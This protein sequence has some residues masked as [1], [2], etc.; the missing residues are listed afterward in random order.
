MT[1]KKGDTIKTALG[2]T[3]T[4]YDVDG[5]KIYYKRGD[6]VIDWIHSGNVTLIKHDEEG[7]YKYIVISKSDG[8]EYKF[9]TLDELKKW[10]YTTTYIVSTT[11][12]SWKDFDELKNYMDD[13]Y[14]GKYEVKR[15]GKSRE[16]LIYERLCNI[17]RPR[18]KVVK[19]RGGDVV[20]CIGDGVGGGSGWKKGLR[21]TI[22][23]MI[24][25]KTE[26]NDCCF[27]G[28]GGNGVYV[29]HLNLISRGTG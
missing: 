17:K 21:F 18:P 10:I 6:G 4:I 24:K 7:D 26:L 3:L 11:I 5:N 25:G 12:D 20:E 19:F 16:Q 9:I 22:K 27:E 13:T 29:H 23:Y 15:A 14:G 2:K 1:F 8:S 28:I